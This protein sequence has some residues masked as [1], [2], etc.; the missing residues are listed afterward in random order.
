MVLDSVQDGLHAD[1]LLQVQSYDVVV[2]FRKLV[3][4]I[5]RASH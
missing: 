5:L 2:G 3:S 1:Q 4:L